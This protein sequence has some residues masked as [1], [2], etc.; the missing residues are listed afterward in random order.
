MEYF[1]RKLLEERE[2]AVNTLKMMEKNHPKSESLREYTQELSF[3]DNHPADHGSELF[4]M[5]M[6]ANLE[7]HQRY[8]IVEIDRALENIEEGIYGKCLLCGVGVPEDRLEL[9]PE[10]N[11]C[12]KCAEGKLEAYKLDKDRPVEEDIISSFYRTPYE[13]NKNY[14]QFDKEDAYQAVAVFNDV[15]GD[16]SF[17]TGDNLGIFDDYNIGSVEEIENISEAYYKSQ[18]PYTGRGMMGAEEQIDKED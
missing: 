2:N 17:S 15:E 12:I 13:N 16:P 4:I 1:K 9:M 8:R 18:L 5:T 6:Q 14:T 11:V 10:A 7:N 3:Y